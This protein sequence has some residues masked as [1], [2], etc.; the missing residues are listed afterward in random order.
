[1]Q[2]LSD[3][4]NVEGLAP[5]GQRG[6]QAALLEPYPA[7]KHGER[8]GSELECRHRNVYPV[9][10][11]YLGFLE[12]TDHCAGVAAGEVEEPEWSRRLVGQQSVQALV[13]LAME[14]AIVV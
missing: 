2:R 9:I 14:H 4:G 8:I 3:P 12:C 13:D 11:R 10:L 6:R 1:M 5:A 7:R